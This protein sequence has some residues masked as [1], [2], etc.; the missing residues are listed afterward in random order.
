MDYQDGTTDN[1]YKLS[2]GIDV[3]KNNPWNG[4]SLGFSASGIDI[5]TFY[6]PWVGFAGGLNEG[7]VSAHIDMY[8]NED[9]NYNLIYIILS[10][11]S[12]ITTGG[13]I[14]YLIR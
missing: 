3:T 14:S 7:D 12:D 11:R 6:I 8:T 2:D 9:D 1:T 10:F 4:Q 13:T 5:D